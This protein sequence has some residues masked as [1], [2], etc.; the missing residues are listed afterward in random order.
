M[1]TIVE[2]LRNSW[3]AFF[4]AKDPS[5]LSPEG[6]V[7]YYRPDRIRLYAGNERTI[8]ASIYN[9]IAVDVAAVDM[10]HVRLDEDK[11][12]IETVNDELNKRLTIS[13]NID[14]DARSFIEDAVTTLLDEGVIAIVPI[15][16]SVDYR[17]NSTFD[18]YSM[19]VAQIIA[20][21]PN[22][23]RVRVYND[24]TGQKEELDY[25]KKAVCILQ[26]PFYQIMNEPN[27][28]LRRLSR[29]LTLLDVVDEQSASGKLDLIVQMP[30]V[31][32]TDT[33]RA[34]AKRRKKDIEM[35][36]AGSKYGIAYID[37]AEKV[38][39]LNRPVENT[40]LNQVEYLT[41]LL[42]S[43]IGITEEIMNGTANEETMVNY[44]NRVIEPIL[45][46]ITLEMTRKWLT[47]TA[48]TK[49]E[50]IKFFRN[51]FK[52]ITLGNIAEIGEK[53]IHNEI[54]SPN[55][56]RSIVGMRPSKDPTSDEIRNRDLYPSDP[57]QDGAEDPSAS[58]TELD[59]LDSS[60]DEIL[61]EY[62]GGTS[63][64]EIEGYESTLDDL[65]KE[66]NNV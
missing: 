6:Q 58:L 52:L 36:L 60:L 57:N 15:D 33:Q 3:N 5:K 66:L 65:L 51:P 53:F 19:R 16:T 22:D 50:V 42:Y 4:N 26:N 28:T 56:V 24:R 54:M 7:S 64:S 59:K 63:V 10:Q 13:A 20:W 27:S 48:I 21:Y 45:S 2:R 41:K 35:Q 12:Y 25:P 29:K 31:V 32:K 46:L 47:T 9:R 30:F 39:Q 44:Y 18:I 49:G 17:K 23:I 8:I 43:Q 11:Q 62:G 38:T 1:P 37:A 40:L 55:E 34:E 61:N 14:Q